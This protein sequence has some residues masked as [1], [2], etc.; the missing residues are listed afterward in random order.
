MCIIWLGRKEGGWKKEADR[1]HQT[2][3][4]HSNL[5]MGSSECSVKAET[6]R[7]DQ[8]RQMFARKLEWEQK[9]REGRMSEGRALVAQWAFHVLAM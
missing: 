2:K 4:V 8:H 1:K 7:D 3:R 5:C 6:V 9:E